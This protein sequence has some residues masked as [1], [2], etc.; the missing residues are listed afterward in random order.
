MKQ[1]SLLMQLFFCLTTILG[2]FPFVVVSAQ[3][4][5]NERHEGTM[6]LGVL[7]QYTFEVRF[8][9]TYRLKEWVGVG[10]DVGL[11][12][13]YHAE[14]IPYGE[15]VSGKWRSW[16]VDENDE[17]VW[18]FFIEPK[19]SFRT[20]DLLRLGK[21]NLHLCTEPGVMLRFPWAMVNVNYYD[22][23]GVRGPS[24]NI[25]SF[26]GKWCFWDMRTTVEFEQD[27]AYL[28]VGYGVSNFDIYAGRRPLAVD[29]VLFDGFYPKHSIA[30]AFF[31]KVGARF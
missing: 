7:S 17:K 25:S 6:S 18:N 22:A 28:A 15:S 16:R 12:K 9:Y 14:E 3:E 1:C 31:V 5:K 27:V 8:G 30:H 20:P 26:G 4:Q 19:L 13:Q 21:W 11:Y 29:N 24:K 2:V 10:A 23:N